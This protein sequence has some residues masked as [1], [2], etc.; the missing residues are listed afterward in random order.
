MISL[1]R[2]SDD[3]GLGQPGESLASDA[4]DAL[5]SAFPGPAARID[6]KGRVMASNAASTP[7]I[8]QLNASGGGLPALA[9]SFGVDQASKVIQLLVPGEG[10]A[11]AT[12]EVVLSAVPDGMVVL[13][14]DTSLAANLRTALAESRKRYKDLVETSSD[15][16]WEVDAH[17]VFNFVSPRGALG[18]R[19]DELLGR[20][21]ASLL[22]DPAGG[23]VDPSQPSPFSTQTPLDRTELWV[24]RSDGSPACVELSATPLC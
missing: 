22:I 12:L 19:A 6:S 17:G 20:P 15:F 14:R 10:G 1:K 9:A 4:L 16:A 8:T 2:P 24:C 23:R 13:G 11:A 18:F 21:A 7:M 5:I 3:D